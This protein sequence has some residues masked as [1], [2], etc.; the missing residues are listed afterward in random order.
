MRKDEAAAAARE[1]ENERRMQEYDAERR[2]AILR[3]ERPPSPPAELE[4]AGQSARPRED[5]HDDGHKR[6]KRKLVGEDDTD[7]DIRVAREDADMV[8]A[9]RDK[10]VRGSRGSTNA[11]LHDHDGHINLFPVDAKAARKA[12]KNAEAEAETK[13]K[14][15]EFE[16]QYTM[17]FSNAA[18][19]EGVE[20]PWY[21]NGLS[22]SKASLP[23]QEDGN[24]DAL[25]ESKDVWGRPDPRRRERQSTRTSANDP[26][27][28]MKKA[29]VQLKDSE[30]D[31]RKWKED[32]DRE[33][34]QLEKVHRAEQRERRRQGK[35]EGLEGF[36]LDEPM[37]SVRDSHRESRRHRHRSRSREQDRESKRRR[38]S[39][40]PGTD[41]HHSRRHHHRE[42]RHD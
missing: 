21:A 4:P 37:S 40:S 38:R 22:K 1:E 5:R 19:R 7:R 39:R 42:R 15:R 13:K 28:F 9:A 31:R 41:Q 27:A 32:R 3:G 8:A 20:R 18:G 14:Q 23:G 34:W 26:L 24:N 33:L 30:R 2:L 10:L 6:K 17:R 35:D 16:D 11:P 25:V 12:E 36:S 29:Q